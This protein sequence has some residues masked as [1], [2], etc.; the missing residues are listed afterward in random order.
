MGSEPG[1]AILSG[2]ELEVRRM[3][4]NPFTWTPRIACIQAA[5]LLPRS[6]DRDFMG[7]FVLLSCNNV[8]ADENKDRELK[9]KL[10]AEA[11][12]IA[13]IAMEAL[14]NLLKRRRFIR[15]ASSFEAASEWNVKSDPVLAW[16]I[17]CGEQT[18]ESHTPG[19]EL[20]DH[21][22][23]WAT[24]NGHKSMA[25]NLFAER[26]AAIGFTRVRSN[27]SRWNL[28]VRDDCLP[29]AQRSWNGNSRD[30]ER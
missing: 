12:L 9:E 10:T 1:K 18:D 17:E 19:K 24:D 23:A 13:R 29:S 27:G 3:R 11:P 26:L 4:E 21:Y 20:Y 30:W 22:R 2:D 14:Q 25:S 28:K 5:N 8:V 6:K 15:P 16:S 7:R